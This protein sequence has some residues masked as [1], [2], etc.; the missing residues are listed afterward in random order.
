MEFHACEYPRTNT[1]SGQGP[2]GL[3]DQR[4]TTGSDSDLRRFVPMASSRR[5]VALALV[6]GGL[7]VA[8]IAAV[9][10]VVAG[11]DD[12]N[13]ARSRARRS[14]TSTVPRPTVPPPPTTTTRAF[15]F[16]GDRA[17]FATGYAFV[18]QPD[19][20]A[21]AADIDTIAATGAR[22]VRFD[23][24][25]SVVQG[26]SREAFDWSTVDPI[27]RRAQA[28]GLS[29]IGLL[30]YSPGWASIDGC[31]G[32][33]C[34]PANPADY[35]TY[36]RAAATRYAPLGV[37]TWELWNE[38]NVPQ[39]WEPSPDPGAYTTLLQATYPAIKAADPTATVLTG[40]TA[41]AKDGDGSYSPASFLSALYDSGAQGNFDALGHHPYAYP[42]HPTDD[43]AHNGFLETQ[44]LA[45]E[46]AAHGDGAKKIWGTETGA[47][48]VGSGVS[49]DDQATW[50]REYYDAW[51]VWAFTGP[52]LW[53]TLRDTQP[54]PG[55]EDSY[56]LL[57]FDRSLKPGFDAFLSVVQ[58]R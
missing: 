52:L 7:V 26:A 48:T 36:T 47:P 2:G 23:M 49:E 42:F 31:R 15:T 37:H 6:A 27:V 21:V 54:D 13:T 35:A 56:G 33:H 20:A 24:E 19:A 12:R 30:G 5:S 29:V 16:T 38:P 50:V 32:L 41:P 45:D 17:G 34:A 39:F 8:T 14:T 10:A 40:G 18:V 58:M 46:M 4:P 28:K 57:H 43:V 11:G 9:I 1:R 44:K 53:Y 3:E 55:R 51:N 25:W 22:W